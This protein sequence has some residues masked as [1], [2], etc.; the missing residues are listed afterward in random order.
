MRMACCIHRV[1]IQL[2]VSTCTD[3]R[4]CRRARAREFVRARVRMCGLA[5]AL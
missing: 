1:P 3:V 4:A 2:G 5:M